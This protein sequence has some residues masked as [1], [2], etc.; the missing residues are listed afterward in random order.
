M[1]NSSIDTQRLA[2]LRPGGPWPHRHADSGAAGA[3]WHG[4]RSG[5][6]AA[7]ERRE[8]SRAGHSGSAA[9]LARLIEQMGGA[10]GSF[11]AGGFVNL[12]A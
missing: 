8:L 2:G 10:E 9:L 5:A 4:V 11:A 3:A 7:W 12:R 1:V 6:A